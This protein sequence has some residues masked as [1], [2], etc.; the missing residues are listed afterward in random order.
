[1]YQCKLLPSDISKR[2][3]RKRTGDDGGNRGLGSG[4]D[5]QETTGG[6][7]GG[8]RGGG[9]EGFWG[10]GVVKPEV[11]GTGREGH[12]C[13]RDRP[14]T[15]AAVS[16]LDKDTPSAKLSHGVLIVM[17]ASRFLQ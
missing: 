9:M 16:V 13:S 4:A 17:A 6:G 12:R 5:G 2:L 3:I 15:Q 1:M 11:T 7:G 8:N 10:G 14:C